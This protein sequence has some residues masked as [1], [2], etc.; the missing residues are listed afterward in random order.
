MSSGAQVLAL[1]LVL[2]V[3]GCGGGA[4]DP[5]E[6]CDA[7]ECPTM[8]CQV[9]S[10]NAEACVY[11]SDPARDGTSCGAAS[12]CRSGACVP[13][14]CGDGVVEVG[15]QC[16]WGVGNGPGVGCELSC[17]Y[18]CTTAPDSCDDG[19]A[20]NGVETCGSVP[21]G[22]GEGQRCAPGT[23]P[24]DGATCGTGKICVDE[25]C[26]ASSCGDGL[27]TAP[28]ECD[29]A[30]QASGD[31]CE[32][33][34]TFSCVATDATRN[35]TPA[36]TCAGQGTCNPTT[37]T[38][39]PGTPLAD[40]TA[41]GV[42]GFCA[43]GVCT[44]PMCGNAVVEP[45]E[46]CDDGAQNGTAAS[47]CKA[48]CTYVCVN[49]AT[50]CGAAPTCQQWTCATD[51]RCLAAADA[52][53]DGT[54][55][56]GGLVCNAGACA[57]P[58]AVCGNGTVETGETCEPP[59]TA[60]CDGSC[61]IIQCG[62]GVRAGAEQCDDGNLTRLDG[63]DPGC[64]FE[65]TL[66]MN[67]MSFQYGTSAYCPRNA[68]GGAV[69]GSST[70]NQLTT[71]VTQGVNDGSITV[72]LHALGLDDLTGAS[73]PAFSVG[74]IGGV[75][76]IGT[77]TY[78]GASDL[79]WWYT[80]I[81]TQLDATRMPRSLVPASIAAN[82]LQ[83]GPADFPLTVSFAGVA[84]TMN[85]LA[86]RFH[87]LVGGTSTP[88]VSTGSPPGHLAAEHLDPALVSFATTSGGEQCGNTTAKSLA[89]TLVPSVVVGCG[90][91]KCT[92]C[93]TS[94]N[95][96]LD[97]YISGCDV[98]LAGQ[99]VR[100]TQPDAARVSGDVYTFAANAQHVVT[101]CTK[102]GQPAVLATCLT[103]AAY[104]SYYRFTTDRVIAK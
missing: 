59:N 27:V 31:G 28:E 87:T 100:P 75:P 16:D 72:M 65:Q 81:A 32:A 85:M 8:P 20:C 79:D 10:C 98:F 12:V 26:T 62:D 14:S 67:T 36:D 23:P 2:V 24:A 104:S 40:T 77:T 95:T 52:A 18:S 7:A 64:R 41:C 69:T 38:C 74:I 22:T 17:A 80:T 54:S 15:E 49:A 102:N 42:G 13:T 61:R 44:Q 33:D 71:A 83:A 21:S 103:D 46:S 19:D 101:S 30:N 50:D 4:A 43:T 56:G 90:F 92:Q 34:C 97:M 9:A 5:P 25:A 78:N 70:R 63:C 35:C 1:V 3:G 94:S 96:L 68:M 48:T 93:F 51:H 58:L 55:C 86:A 66:R 82:Q 53:R 11:T 39:T 6:T 60:A 37:H 89:D 45:G 99:Q 29:D 88:L 84:V 47:G 57:S 91:G 73:D 76:Q